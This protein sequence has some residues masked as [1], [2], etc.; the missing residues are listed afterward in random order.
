[1]KQF[2][3]H[4]SCAGPSHSEICFFHRKYALQTYSLCV[5]CFRF[6]GVFCDIPSIKVYRLPRLRIFLEQGLQTR[7][8]KFSS[9]SMEMPIFFK[10]SAN[11]TPPISFLLQGLNRFSLDKYP[12]FWEKLPNFVWALTNT[13][14][15]GC[16]TS[17]FI[18][19]RKITLLTLA[20]RLWRFLF[21]LKSIWLGFVWQLTWQLTPLGSESN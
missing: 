18:K 19:P 11:T 15:I 2:S 13:A 4:I 16:H 5:D 6:S 9:S 20:L 8:E 17:T 21:Y 1:M 3:L 12:S 7:S 14:I 10:T